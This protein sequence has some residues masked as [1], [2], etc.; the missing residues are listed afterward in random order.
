MATVLTTTQP[1]CIDA[2]VTLFRGLSTVTGNPPVAV[3]DGEPGGQSED[4]YLQVGG[5]STPTTVAGTQ[6]WGPFGISGVTAPT[7]DETFVIICYAY[8]FV[9][10]VQ[11]G[12]NTASD[13]QKTARDQAYA[14][15]RDAET[16]LRTDPKLITAMTANGVTNPGVGTG[17]IALTRMDLLQNDST[18]PQLGLGRRAIVE[19]DITVYS[20]RYTT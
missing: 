3:Y 16:G 7:R 8:A 1:D 15:V 20:R 4:K 9:G 11:D 2:L 12:S 19:F 6:A 13:A 10:G 5:G 18:D 17:W 14:L